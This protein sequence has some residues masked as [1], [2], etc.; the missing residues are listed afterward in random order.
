MTESYTAKSVIFDFADNWGYSGYMGICAIEFFEDDTMI[1]LTSSDFT[2]Y[3]TTFYNASYAPGL[4]FDTSLSKLVGWGSR[5]WVTAT[6]N[7]SNQR[8]IVV[9]NSEQT[10]NKIVINNAHSDGITL[11]DPG[12]KNSRIYVSSDSI[13]DTTYNAAISNSELIFDDQIPIHQYGVLPDDTLLTTANFSEFEGLQDACL[14]LS[15][16][17]LVSEFLQNSTL[18][19][20][21]MNESNTSLPL[22]L[23]LGSERFLNMAIDI[24]LA[25]GTITG[26]LCLD[27]K[28][29]DGNKVE[30]L[31]MDVMVVAGTPELKAVYAMHLDSAIK[32]ITS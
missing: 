20:S 25:D 12:V 22:D 27:I 15:I 4:A 6:G 5:C 17:S 11:L 8:V 31:G 21:V 26:D 16:T 10:F 24:H 30:N 29:G 9:F 32:E 13:T 1:A 23:S 7:D 3:A 14:D 19:L 2:A 28:L 18:D